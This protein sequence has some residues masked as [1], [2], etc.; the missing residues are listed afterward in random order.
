MTAPGSSLDFRERSAARLA[1]FAWVV[2]GFTVFVVLFGAVVRVTGSG[3]GCGQHWP[4]CHGELTHL[5][6]SLETAIEYTHR[7]T[8]GLSLL[9]VGAWLIGAYRVLPKR[10]AGR[11][12]TVSVTV[13]MIVEALI[14]AVLV[15]LALVAESR[16]PLRALVMPLHL[17]N[18]SLL[19]GAMAWGAMLIRRPPGP[20]R[21]R[22][23]SSLEW[24]VAASLL[25]TLVVSGTG[26]V[27]ALGDTLFPVREIGL[28]HRLGE[29]YGAGAHW[30]QRFRV[31]H[32]VVAF[33]AA[34]FIGRVFQAVYEQQRHARAG[35]AA[36]VTLTLVITQLMV[37][38]LNVWL[39]A[40]AWMQIVHLSFAV[41]V[42]L[43]QVV[44]LRFLLDQ[45][46]P[47]RV[48]EALASAAR[49]GA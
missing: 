10:H 5:P 20:W 7:V 47:A 28:Q 33:A 3:A 4:T 11:P 21:A 19:L 13:L 17:V 43:G 22:P 44:T 41:A 14:G 25:A 26:A 18:T 24:L 15:L 6:S 32:P 39:S 1:K 36:L 12:L 23:A 38:L 42:W 49:E 34:L 30:L 45:V 16:S 35:R 31:V 40:P 27:T 48:S 9:L 37:G 2:L 46:A 8:S 29:D